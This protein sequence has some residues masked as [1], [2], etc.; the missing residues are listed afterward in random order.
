MSS[1]PWLTIGS[2]RVPSLWD[3][4]N[5]LLLLLESMRVLRLFFRQMDSLLIVELSFPCW[6]RLIERAVDFAGLV[7]LWLVFLRMTFLDVNPILMH[8]Q[9]QTMA[10][11]IFFII[12]KTVIDYLHET[13]KIRFIVHCFWHFAF[14]SSSMH[15]SDV[16]SSIQW[17]GVSFPAI[18]IQSL[19]IRI[20]GIYHLDHSQNSS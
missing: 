9:Y 12:I 20:S 11:H 10:Y 19:L 13:N 2:I 8:F 18:L 7:T 17:S 16:S 14:C 3:P 4:C 6:C 15:V 1:Y 5:K